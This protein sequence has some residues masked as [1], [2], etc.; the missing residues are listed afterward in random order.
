LANPITPEV[1]RRLHWLLNGPIRLP[2]GMLAAWVGKS[3]PAY[4]YQ[5]ATGY[6]LSLLCWLYQRTGGEEYRAEAL[7]TA[8]SLVNDIAAKGGCGRDGS[9]YLFD[10]AV[11]AR[12]LSLLIEICPADESERRRIADAGRRLT[13]EALEMFHAKRAFKGGIGNVPERHWS[14][15]YNVHMNKAIQHL[16]AQASTPG[17]VEEF[18]AEIEKW[19]ATRYRD[20]MFFSDEEKTSVNIHAHL[21][22]LE[23]LIAM[24]GESAP[25]W[26]PLLSEAAGRLVEIQAANGALPRLHPAVESPEYT[27]D[28]T[29]QA[30]R[31][32]QSVDPKRYQIPISRGLE[33]LRSMTSRDGGILYSSAIP[34]INSWAT[35]FTIQAMIRQEGRAESEWII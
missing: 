17:P 30:V 5:E 20:G 18:R 26:A 6:L 15:T 12:A 35:I 7:R 33:F 32:W 1:R 24:R 13:E 21:Y 19:I 14:R 27:T 22:A 2:D 3:G 16:A 11:C 28:V 34:H 8:T 31:V 10:T 29:A 23:G 25:G 9:V 4:A